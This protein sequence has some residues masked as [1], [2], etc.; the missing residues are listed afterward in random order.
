MTLSYEPTGQQNDVINHSGPAFVTACPG[1][2][3]TRTMV[4]RARRLAESREDRRGVAFLS[5]TK[6]A[7]HE[8]E[9]R[10]RES[11]FLPS[12]LFPSFIGTFDRFLW[13]FLIAPFG[14]AGS[15][16]LPKLVPDKENWEVNPFDRQSLPLKCF[17]R[18][19]GAVNAAMARELGFDTAER[20][21]RP[22]EATARAILKAAND[23]GQVDF[24]DVRACV[25]ERLLDSDL[26]AR[27]G[28]ALAARFCEIVVDEAQDCNPFDLKVVT[29]LL[30]AGIAV[31]VICDP[32]QSIYEF[33][34]GITDE[35]LKFAETFD[36]GC[37]LPMSG[38][39]RSN[40]A[41]CAAIVAFRPP[42]ARA[43]PDEPLG[44]YK[45]DRTPVHLISYAGKGVS[46]GIGSKFGDLV[47]GLGIP[48]ESAPVLASTWNSASKAVGQPGLKSRTEDK[49]LLL[50]RASMSYQFAFASGNR[51]ETLTTLHRIILWVQGHIGGS[52]EYSSYLADNGMEDGRWRPKVIAIANGLQFAAGQTPEQWL[53]RARELLTPGTVA[54]VKINKRLKSNGD[55][56]RVLARAP[57]DSPPPHAIHSV[58]GKEFPAV[59]VVMTSQTAGGILGYLEGETSNG[60]DEDVRKIYVAASRAE[61]LLAIAVPRSSADRLESL[62]AAQGC[63]TQHHEI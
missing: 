52:G 38:N 10:L 44:R 42:H 39:F 8:F 53:A 26:S 7:V 46:T 16:A 37:R 9:G 32:H 34:G 6:A 5:F 62:L 19:T 15:S 60:M 11:A 59:C 58:K 18:A 47:K 1:A 43:N 45:E 31:K 49:T 55:L 29:W 25:R 23:R 30:N 20:D 17:D 41:I 35:L 54:G 27:L 14:I 56:G 12:P 21:I 36:P 22:Y 48:L 3:K 61:R 28:A 50:A 40:P 57:E 24:E 33:R 63:P 51:R 2:G 13:Q 4:E